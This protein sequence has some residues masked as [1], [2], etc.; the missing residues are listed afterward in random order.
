MLLAKDDREIEVGEG[1]DLDT[2]LGEP[3]IPELPYPEVI[4][5]PYRFFYK[6]KGNTVWI[7]AVWYGVQLPKEP[8]S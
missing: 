7:V 4:V 5:P 6:V 8:K 2:V 1:F 3:E